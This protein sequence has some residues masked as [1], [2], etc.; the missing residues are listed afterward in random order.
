MD[1][2][3][4]VGLEIGGSSSPKSDRK[5]PGQNLGNLMRHLPVTRGRTRQI[6]V[7]DSPVSMALI[8][9]GVSGR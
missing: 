6:V 4:G 9:E 3:I 7:A 8:Y 5:S 2:E 1:F